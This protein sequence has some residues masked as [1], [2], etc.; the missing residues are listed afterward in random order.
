[1]ISDEKLELLGDNSDISIKGKT[2]HVQTEIFAEPPPPTIKTA[3][4]HKGRLIKKISFDCSKLL[5]SGDAYDIL[6][7]KVK[8]QHTGAVSELQNGLISVDE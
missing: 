5:S 2:F 1:M 7:E 3:I 4:Y 6:K 8:E